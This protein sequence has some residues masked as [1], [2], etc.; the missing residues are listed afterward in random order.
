M[1][2]FDSHCHLQEPELFDVLPQVMRD[3]GEAGVARMV[4]CGTR[5]SDWQRTVEAG[6][7]REGVVL[8]LGL[9]PWYVAHRGESWL[10]RLERL[11]GEGARGVG[12]IGL[13]HALREVPRGEQ[14]DVFVAQ[15]RLA[16]RLGVP[17]AVH[18]RKAW[19]ALMEVLRREGG[20]GAGGV[21]H[22]YSGP[23]EFVAELEEMGFYLSFSGSI[24]RDLNK[25]GPRSLAA[26][27]QSRLLVETDAPAI[28]P[29]GVQAPVN[30]PATLPRVVQAVARLRG[31][32]P[33][34]AAELTFENAARLFRPLLG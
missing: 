28:V 31:L 12:E 29:A 13:D 22:S 30:T 10:A 18:C 14:L 1:K 11:L 5:E 27:S 23:P 8:M 15:V 32:S 9:H 24:T 16:A 25:R 26:V 34:R 33:E 19:G 7:G 21:M 4:C 20:V 17:V 6:C 2:L 3:A